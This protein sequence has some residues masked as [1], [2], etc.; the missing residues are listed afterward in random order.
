MSTTTDPDHFFQTTY[1]LQE[2]TRKNLK[3]KNTHGNPIRLSSK[4]LAAISDPSSLHNAIYVAESAGNV[5]RIALDTN[6]TT[7]LYRGP[8]APLTSLAFNP[9]HTT[10]FAGCWDKTI[11]SWSLSTRAPQHRYTG[12]H[13]DFIKTLLML[14]LASTSL[15]FSGSADSN[16]V[17]WSID[18]GHKLH[19]LTGH[20]RGILA[21]ALDPFSYENDDNPSPSEN[22]TL[23]SASSD[24]EIRRWRIGVDGCE[25]LEPETPILA[26]ETSVY[27]LTFDADGDL[28]TASADGTA[29]CLARFNGW[30]PDTEL[31]HGDFV[32]SVVVDELGGMVVTGGR[33]ED[34]KVWDKGSG[35]L[36]H[37]YRGHYE[38]VTALV[39]VG[40][41][42]VSVGIDGT[43]RRWGLRAEELREAKRREEEEE[44]GKEEEKEVVKGGVLTEEEEREL[45][46]LM[47]ED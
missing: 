25:Q 27:A 45:A 3:S 8:T 24:R 7:A 31:R 33:D 26:H 34:V 5:H 15:L 43:V 1:S 19:V 32:S 20:S 36:V 41:E 22:I 38:E 12:G 13:T 35:E 18:S 28:W 14:R 6:E 44:E 39:V 30:R 40:R 23:F 4:I 16:I 46:E 9:Q 2:T 37:V 21:L 42:V 10:L 29:K 17:I 47:A 11:W